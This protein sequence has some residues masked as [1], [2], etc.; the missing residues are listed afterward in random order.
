M[1]RFF[2]LESGGS[3]PYDWPIMKAFHRQVSLAVLLAGFLVMPELRAADLYYFMQEIHV[4]GEGGWNYSSVDAAGRRLYVSH[5]TKVIVI[6]I[7]KDQIAGQ[8]TGTPG[9]HGFAIAPSLH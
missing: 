9:V 8:I 2:M 6:D 7:D 1:A 5:N 4:G 3:R